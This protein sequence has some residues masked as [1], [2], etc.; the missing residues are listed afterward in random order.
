M[1]LLSLFLCFS[2]SFLRTVADDHSN[3]FASPGLG[4]RTWTR[5]AA[6]YRVTQGRSLGP[7]RLSGHRTGT[8][9]RPQPQ[10]TPDRTKNCNLPPPPP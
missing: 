5:A 9:R 6:F 3:R 4:G 1:V 7:F 2:D 10:R 8:N